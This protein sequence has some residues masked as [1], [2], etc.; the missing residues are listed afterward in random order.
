MIVNPARLDPKK[1]R[2][3]P[4]FDPLTY[5]KVVGIDNLYNIAWLRE[6]LEKARPVA[7][8]VKANGE[9][10]T[11]FLIDDNRLVTNHHVLGSAA[12]A[13]S[14][15]AQFNVETNWAG[16]ELPISEFALA[17]DDLF[18]TDEE[19]DYTIVRVTDDAQGGL[20]QFGSLDP[21]TVV[22]PEVNDYV[23]VIQ[24][25]YGGTKQI[26]LTDNK[27]QAVLG[28]V[29]QYHADAL[30]GASGSPVFNEHWELVA[31]HARGG[32]LSGGEGALHWVNEGVLMSA[33][34]QHAAGMPVASRGEESAPNAAVDVP[35]RPAEAPYP[36]RLFFLVFAELRRHVAS[37][38]SPAK[39]PVDAEGLSSTIIASSQLTAQFARW[40]AELEAE[41][42]EPVDTA[43]REG[44]ACGAAFAAEVRPTGHESLNQPF[45][46][47]GLPGLGMR[48]GDLYLAAHRRMEGDA[49]IPAILDALVA[50][51]RRDP[52]AVVK[53]FAAGLLAGGDRGSRWAPWHP[54][55]EVWP[56]RPR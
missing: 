38:L 12:E 37:L 34:L 26:C 31:L 52:D 4:L 44:C 45:A 42:L 1:C 6:G 27:V 21:S 25:P 56:K 17:P 46:L 49:E 13:R 19:L 51:L 33:V 10:A 32:A 53:A 5:E 20:R 16:D 54:D 35:S 11:G 24:Q 36:M 22:Q 39:P 15:T 3:E 30:P 7:R 47:R 55:D 23:S 14:A 2:S 8:V 29:L 18:V 28:T 43:V 9:R 50:D 48:A 41:G 40:K